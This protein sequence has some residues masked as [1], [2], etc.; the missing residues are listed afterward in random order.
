LVYKPSYGRRNLLIAKMALARW[1]KT[2]K[3]NWNSLT[4]PFELPV[5]LQRLLPLPVESM[6]GAVEGALAV[7]MTMFPRA[8]SCVTNSKPMPLDAP[9]MSH[10]DIS[11]YVVKGIKFAMEEQNTR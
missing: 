9:T 5:R 10:T 11:F 7:A 8:S 6:E 2:S 4:C 3:Q 1:G